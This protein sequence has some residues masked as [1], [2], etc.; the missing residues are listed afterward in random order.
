MLYHLLVPLARDHI[1]F[2]QHKA[3]QYRDWVVC[4][5]EKNRSGRNLVE[6]EF[7]KRFEYCCFNPIGSRVTCSPKTAGLGAFGALIPFVSFSPRTLVHDFGYD[8]VCFASPGA[9]TLTTP[10]VPLATA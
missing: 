4:T 1:V 5:I 2:N 9:S 3:Q 10:V 8:V 7:M 6:V